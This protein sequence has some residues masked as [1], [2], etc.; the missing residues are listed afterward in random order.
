MQSSVVI[1]QNSPT[2]V[3]SSLVY[4]TN[5]ATE[6]FYLFIKG[7]IHQTEK[8]I[9]SQ[10]IHP[11]EWWK[12]NLTCHI[13]NM[14]P[15]SMFHKGECRTNASLV[16]IPHMCC[17]IKQFMSMPQNQ[18]HSLRMVEW[19]THQDAAVTKKPS[20]HSRWFSYCLWH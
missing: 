7:F 14:T 5:G 1:A 10:W 16:S 6:P 17:I 18:L 9:N 13:I 4:T 3:Q 11:Y 12:Y 20:T 19:R 15:S 8:T 2:F